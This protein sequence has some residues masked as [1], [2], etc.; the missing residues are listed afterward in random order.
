LILDKKKKE[1][2]RKLM[3]F[4]SG[5]SRSYYEYILLEQDGLFAN[6]DDE[7]GGSDTDSDDN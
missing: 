2:L 3:E 4:L 7:E 1:D 5:E 6:E